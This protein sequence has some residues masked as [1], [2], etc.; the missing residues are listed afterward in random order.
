LCLAISFIALHQSVFTWVALLADVDW[1]QHANLPQVLEQEFSPFFSSES[2][3]EEFAR[4]RFDL[5]ELN[6]K[7]DGWVVGPKGTFRFGIIEHEDG[8][9][10]DVGTP[11]LWRTRC[12]RAWSPP[13]VAHLGGYVPRPRCVTRREPY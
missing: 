6:P 4:T 3:D 13:F 8:D 7:I 5:T 9:R 2:P 12:D 11:F 10:D 1:E